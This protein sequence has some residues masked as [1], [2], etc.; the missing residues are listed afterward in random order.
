MA[1]LYDY[2]IWRG[3]IPFAVRP[4]NAIDALVFCQLSYLNFSEIVPARFDGGI[5]LREAARIYAESPVHGVPEEFGVFINPRTADLLAYAAGTE[6][7]G[8][9]LLAGFVNEVDRTAD[10]QF[11]ALT[12]VLPSG[13]VCVVYRGTDDSIVGW[14]EDCLLCLP[15]PIPSHDAAAQYFAAAAHAALCSGQ[16]ISIAGHSKGGNLAL[17]AAGT[18]AASVQQRIEHVFC[19]DGPGFSFDIERAAGFQTIIP[20]TQSFIPQ[21]SVVGVLLSYLPGH[22]V[23]DST[24]TNTLLQHDVFSWQILRDTFV[25]HSG[26][27][28]KESYFAEQTIQSWLARLDNAERRAFIE[29]LFQI[30]Y[31]TGAETL[32]ELTADGIAHSMTMIKELRT[33]APERRKELFNVLKFFFEAAYAQFPLKQ[34]LNSNDSRKVYE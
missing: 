34:A 3:D 4:F 30:M 29:T 25:Q 33:V 32:K 7:F 12:A 19:F 11:A 5:T 2:L 9:V 24:E 26:G 21:S 8:N 27:R 14:K 18:A 20:K 31:C 17:Y 15:E 28:S 10:K 22:T 13:G 6:R 23:I 1:N 16:P